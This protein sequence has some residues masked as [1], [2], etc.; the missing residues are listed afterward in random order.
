MRGGRIDSLK[1][2]ERA[3]KLIPLVGVARGITNFEVADP[4]PAETA[5]DCQRLN[6][7]AYL[8]PTQ[9]LQHACVEKKIYCH[10]S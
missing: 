4:R 3:D 5:C 1:C 6:D 2:V 8:G 9:T 7:L 10:A